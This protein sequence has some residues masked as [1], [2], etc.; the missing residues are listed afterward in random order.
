MILKEWIFT[1]YFF[2]QTSY[3]F[4][5]IK[6]WDFR[7]SILYTDLISLTELDRMFA[8]SETRLSLEERDSTCDR[9]LIG[10]ESRIGSE[11]EF[12]IFHREIC[13]FHTLDPDGS[14]DN[15]NSFFC[16]IGSEVGDF[17]SSIE[18]SMETFI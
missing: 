18:V 9:R 11:A 5:W 6:S 17:S 7:I 1:Q 15:L 8:D 2:A 13:R 3:F 10:D 4:L 16:F 14:I 12:Y